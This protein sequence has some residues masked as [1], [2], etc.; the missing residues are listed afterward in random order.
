VQV[1]A[2]LSDRLVI[3]N[4]ELGLPTKLSVQA[5][6]MFVELL[7]IQHFHNRR[8]PGVERFP[9]AGCRLNQQEACFGLLTGARK[10]FSTV[11]V[12]KIKTE[13]V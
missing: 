10:V 1:E 5:W 7:D 12:K 4:T 13:L 6:S 11:V 8:G 9:T 3:D 2:T